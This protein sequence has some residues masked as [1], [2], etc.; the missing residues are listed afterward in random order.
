RQ[1]RRFLS[2]H[3]ATATVSLPKRRYKKDAAA[4]VFHSILGFAL[5][6]E[7]LERGRDRDAI[8]ISQFYGSLDPASLQTYV[9][10]GDWS[11]RFNDKTAARESYTKAL[12][13]DPTNK[14]ASEGLRVLQEPEKK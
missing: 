7:L 14:A 8:A 6:D 5:V 11:R 1:I 9:N 10:K 2:E 13:L 4:P 12:R 3:G